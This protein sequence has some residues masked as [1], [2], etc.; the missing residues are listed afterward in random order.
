MPTRLVDHV[1]ILACVALAAS[2]CQSYGGSAAAGA[3]AGATAGAIIGHQ[4]GNQG[5]GA[6]IGA[7]LGGLT[8]LIVHDV[9][10]QKTKS[11]QQTADSLGYEATQGEVLQLEDAQI[12]PKNVRPGNQAEATIQYALLG[13]GEGTA[14][15]EQ[16]VLEQKGK[17]VAMLSTKN[18][19]RSAGTWV[20]TLPFEVPRDLAPGQYTM[21]QV[22]KTQ[23]SQV[24]RAQDFM[25]LER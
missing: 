11:A 14:V 18:F 21:V 3:A 12:Y 16:R 25:V 7:V 13:V 9:K 15:M 22:V 2:G 10:A 24:S 19:T 1:A 5:E 23:R 6:L 17:V 4:S 8:G 20:S